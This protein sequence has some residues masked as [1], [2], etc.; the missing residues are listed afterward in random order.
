MCA[1]LTFAFISQIGSTSISAWGF[2]FTTKRWGFVWSEMIRNVCLPMILM[3]TSLKVRLSRR[4]GGIGSEQL[5][6]GQHVAS[7]GKYI[8][9]QTHLSLYLGTCESDLRVLA[10]IFWCHAQRFC[11]GAELNEMFRY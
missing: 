7:F 1:G 5:L 9:G 4:M 6:F 3:E 11:W 2:A 8:F 10:S